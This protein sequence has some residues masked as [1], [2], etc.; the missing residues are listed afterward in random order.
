MSHKYQQCR[1]QCG[2]THLVC[3]LLAGH[4]RVG[5]EITLVGGLDN[6]R[7]VVKEV[8]QAVDERYIHAIHDLDVLAKVK[9]AKFYV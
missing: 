7:W 6:R 9:A 2:T 1:L 3:M 5:D 8:G 4:V